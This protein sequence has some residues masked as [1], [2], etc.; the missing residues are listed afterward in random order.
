QAQWYYGFAMLLSSF[1]PLILLGEPARQVSRSRIV[2]FFLFSF[3]TLYILVV[4]GHFLFQKAFFAPERPY[5][6]WRD[7]ELIAR[8]L[9]SHDSQIKL[10]ELDDGLTAFALD[11]PCLHLLAVDLDTFTAMQEGRLL[12]H[13]CDKGHNVLAS[14]EYMDALYPSR[15]SED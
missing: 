10:L 3:Y 6:Y 11:I 14:F 5:I 4:S 12:R 13:A 7:R 1:L 2:S 15:S 9:K 8:A